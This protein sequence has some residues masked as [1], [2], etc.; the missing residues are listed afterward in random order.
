VEAIS[1]MFTFDP[2]SYGP[3]LGAILQEKHLNPL[4]PGSPTQPTPGNLAALATN[5]EQAFAPHPVRDPDMAAACLA[6]LWLYHNY[7]DQSHQISQGIESASGSYWHGLMHRREPDFSNAKYWFRR[8]GKHPVFALLHPAAAKLAAQAEQHPSIRFLA[9]QPAW[10]PF[11]F[12][13]LCEACL[14]GRSPHTLLCQ[15]IQQ[16]EWESLF[17]YCYRQACGLA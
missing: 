17:D 1:I 9:T 2:Q 7:L 6:G 5:L 15:Q 11:A 14:E 13:D 10:D 12:I 8:V 16:R 3:F 4:G